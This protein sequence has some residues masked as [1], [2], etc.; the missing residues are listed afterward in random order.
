M[1]N[2][3]LAT[4]LTQDEYESFESVWES[5]T[6]KTITRKI[7]IPKTKVIKHPVQQPSKPAAN[8]L[9]RTANKTITPQKPL[10]N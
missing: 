9:V 10:P 8:N 1:Q 6:Q 3:Q 5:Q 2:R 7:S 4:W